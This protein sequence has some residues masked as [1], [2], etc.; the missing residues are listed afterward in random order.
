MRKN[1]SK[2]TFPPALPSSRA[3]LHPQFPYLIP[4]SGT[5]GWG[6]GVVVSSSHVVSA[7]PPSSR[8]SPAPAWGPTHGR[9]SF[10]IFSSVSPSHG[11]QIFTKCSSVGPFHRVQSIKNGLL[12]C[13]SPP[14]ATGPARKLAPARAVHGVTASFRA[15]PPAPAWGPPRAAGGQPASPWSSPWAAGE[16]L[17]WRLEHLLPLLL[18]RPRCLQS[19]FSHI[20]SLLSPGCCCTA[21]FS[22]LN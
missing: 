15:H 1:K 16:S 5:G 11:V 21:V 7:T 2:S 14:G 19:C 18:H 10:M 13:G 6:M 20:F 22:P 4:S 9:Q 12:Q 3:Q 8:S 17:L